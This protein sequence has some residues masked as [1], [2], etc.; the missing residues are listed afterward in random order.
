VVETGRKLVD[1]DKFTIKFSTS[2]ENFRSILNG[3]VTHKEQ[4]FIPRVIALENEKVDAPPKVATAAVVPSPTLPAAS[5]ATPGNP[6]APA[7]AVPAATP[8]APK[9]EYVFGKENVI[10][11]MDLELVDVKEPESKAEA[12]PEPKK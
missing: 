4:F 11:T 10:V 1:K 3:I 2:Q 6:A 8:E 12:K 7:A 5:A 9:L